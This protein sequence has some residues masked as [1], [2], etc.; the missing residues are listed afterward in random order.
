MRMHWA[1][2]FLP[3]HEVPY[4]E[5]E[6]LIGMLGDMRDKLNMQIVEIQNAEKKYRT[7]FERAVE[8]IFQSTP[9]G[10]L[11]NVNPAMAQMLGYQS[12]QALIQSVSD[13]GEQLYVDPDRRKEFI[14]QINGQ[15]EVKAFHTEFRTADGKTVWLS[16]YSRPVRDDTGNLLYI[17]GMALDISR[18][19]ARR[20]GEKKAG[21]TI[22][23]FPET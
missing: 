15:K 6:P 17:E 2:R 7:I 14:R 1:K 16:L 18:Q 20:G 13:I 8:G 5:F 4:R 21:S 12:S 3:G 10:H 19:K 22:D 23:S 9:D 11:I